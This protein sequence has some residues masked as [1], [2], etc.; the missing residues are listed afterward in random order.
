[1]KNPINLLLTMELGRT[2]FSVGKTG[3]LIEFLIA[4]NRERAKVLSINKIGE[5]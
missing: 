1:M 5:Y 4:R 2:E 3:L